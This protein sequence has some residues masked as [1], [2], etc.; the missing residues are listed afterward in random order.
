MSPQVFVVTTSVCEGFFTLLERE[1]EQLLKN[2]LDPLLA[3][4]I[5]IRIVLMQSFASAGGGYF[6]V[7]HGCVI[8]E[9]AIS[10]ITYVACLASDYTTGRRETPI[11]RLTVLL[12]VDTGS[13]DPTGQIF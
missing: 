9:G 7:L 11:S 1:I 6:Y 4:T 3:V 13:I 10:R 8:G 2:G 12:P 5:H